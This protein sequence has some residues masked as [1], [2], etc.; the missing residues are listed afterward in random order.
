MIGNEIGRHQMRKKGYELGR[1][2]IWPKVAHQYLRVFRHAQESFRDKYY[3]QSLPLLQEPLP[4]INLGH[5]IRLTDDTGII[6]HSVYGLPDWRFG[7]SADDVGRALVAVLNAYSQ[8]R[9]ENCLNLA[10]TYLSFLR[11]AQLES[12]RFHNFMDY[13]RRF[14]DEEGSE[15]TLGR[16]IWG[17]G[18][19]VNLGP[20]E[21]FRNLARELLEKAIDDIQL[22]YPMPR[23]YVI[24]GLYNFLQRYG[25]ATGI[26]R[27]LQSLADDLVESYRPRNGDWKWFGPGVSYG[28]AKICQ[29]LLLAYK[30]LGNNVHRQVALDALKFLTEST[31]NGE[32]F[33]FTGNHYWI[34]DKQGRILPIEQ[35]IDTGYMV[36]ACILAHEITGEQRFLELARTAFEWFLGRNR[37]GISLYD[38]STGACCDGL[39][40]NGVNLNKGA[41]S[42]ICFL[43]ANLAM[44]E[45]QIKIAPVSSKDLKI[46][47][48]ALYATTSDATNPK[49]SKS[50]MKA[51]HGA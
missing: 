4:E 51:D 37:L 29:A 40:C 17:L 41:E 39:E 34:D 36:E 31:F 26:R 24:L 20:L 38:F 9:D 16:C 32:Y 42:T 5:I 25:G 28:P 10:N 7:Y 35:P 50:E 43:I 2:M 27:L 3:F 47:E 46:T 33:N 30:V 14:T 45:L 19:A 13:S 18:V 49:D 22:T 6:Q 1:E 12:G 21:D 44:A 23:A 48:A 11:Y 15:D 8:T